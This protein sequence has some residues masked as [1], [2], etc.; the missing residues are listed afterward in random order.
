MTAADP[1]TITGYHAHIY[2]GPETRDRAA[3]IRDALAQRFPEARLGRWRDEPVG[4]HPQA[5]YQVAFPPELFPALVPWL[6]LNRSGLAVL[7]HPETGNDYRDHAIHA[8][9][10]GAMLPLDTDRLD[11]AR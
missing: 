3:L 4:P 7:V 10:L 11:G 2:Y 6:M 5:M 1:A 9:W 8:L